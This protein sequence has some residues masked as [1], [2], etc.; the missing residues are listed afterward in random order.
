MQFVTDSGT[1]LSLTAA[2]MAELNI[3]VVPLTVTLDEIS[4]QEG[5]DIQPEAFYRLQEASDNMP[6][7]SQPSAGELA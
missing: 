5:L 2:E 7:T 1:D 3:H 6:T 4:Y